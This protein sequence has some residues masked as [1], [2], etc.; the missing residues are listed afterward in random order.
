MLDVS[1]KV[2]SFVVVGVWE[3]MV[4]ELFSLPPSLAY[5]LLL[6][7]LPFLPPTVSLPVALLL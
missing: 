6:Q 7:S 1:S 4:F 2:A 5:S 3:A